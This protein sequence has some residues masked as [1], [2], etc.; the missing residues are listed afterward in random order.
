M[1]FEHLNT[2]KIFGKQIYELKNQIEIFQ[3][4][5]ESHEKRKDNFC[6]LENIKKMRKIFFTFN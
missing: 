4:K 6:F 1:N 2:M 3:K 5:L